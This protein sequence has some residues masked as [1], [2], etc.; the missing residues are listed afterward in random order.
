MTSKPVSIEEMIVCVERELKRRLRDYPR[1]VIIGRM[2]Q[3]TAALEI[4]RMS[5]VLDNLKLQQAEAPGLEMVPID[6]LKGKPK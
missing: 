2:K 5:A 6:K 3:E 1:V 4:A